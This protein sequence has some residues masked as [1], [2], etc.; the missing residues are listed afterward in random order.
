[1]IGKALIL[2]QIINY[3]RILQTQVEVILDDQ[4]IVI[5]FLNLFWYPTA[6]N[7]LSDLQFL[8]AKLASVNPVCINDFEVDFDSNALTQEVIKCT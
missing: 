6:A 7:V 2:D 5:S 8:A 3:V 1:M 4:H